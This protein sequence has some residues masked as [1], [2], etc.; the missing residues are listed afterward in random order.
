[1]AIKS[2]VCLLHAALRYDSPEENLFILQQ[3][4]EKALAFSPD[5]ILTPELALSGYEFEKEIG[6]DWIQQGIEEAFD[7]FTQFARRNRV[8]VVLGSPT[9]EAGSDVYHNSA[10]L[11]DEYGNIAGRHH[12]IN[13]L[14]GS[15]AWAEKGTTADPILWNGNQVGVLICS[16]MYTD[17]IVEQ[18]ARQ[19]AEVIFSPAN[20]SPGLH[21]PN[22]EW[23]ARSLENGLTVVVCNRTGKEVQMD[24]R[25]SASVVI[26]EGQRVLAYARPEPAVLCVA[27]DAD[28]RPLS[29]Q[30]EILLV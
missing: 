1:M 16:D 30:F 17:T 28:W 5:V 13:V 8:A 2:S 7:W 12:K 29:E 3:M 23:E 24:F 11:I 26:V 9:Y 14:S 6:L 20:W 4:S 22:G 19:G 27:F 25:G 10:T 15:E 18:A 21:G